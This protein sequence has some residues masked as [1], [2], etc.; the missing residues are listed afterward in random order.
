MAVVQAGGKW[1]LLLVRAMECMDKAYPASILGKEQS[2]SIG[3]QV[4]CPDDGP[5]PGGSTQSP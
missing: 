3:P 4:H 5:G 1:A 2:R